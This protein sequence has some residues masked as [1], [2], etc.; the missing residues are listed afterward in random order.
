MS[1]GYLEPPPELRELASFLS[2]SGVVEITQEAVE[3]AAY[4]Y[5]LEGNRDMGIFGNMHY[6][7]LVNRLCN[8]IQERRLDMAIVPAS[9][10]HA[11]KR[12]RFVLRFHRAKAQTL[13]PLHG[14]KAREH[15]RTVTSIGPRLFNDEPPMGKDLV[16]SIV[17]TPEHSL[18][19]MAVGE[20]VQAAGKDEWGYA[21]EP[22]EIYSALGGAYG[23]GTPL[24]PDEDVPTPDVT[25]RRPGTDGKTGTADA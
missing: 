23:D 5:A 15:A 17:S 24:P 4:A 25:L 7:A 9:I 8:A 3:V 22:V 19:R 13:I 18:Q 16:V 1:I 12:D 21:Y 14:E 2:E 11:F 20:L 6:F 10:K